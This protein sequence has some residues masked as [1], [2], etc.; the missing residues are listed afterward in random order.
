MVLKTFNL[1]EETYEKF[2]EFCRENGISMSKQINI[3]IEAQVTENPKV[4]AA[5]LRK[6]DAIRKGKFIKVSSIGDFKK[7]YA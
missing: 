1:D 2:S 6:L 4:R 5:Y 7:R 3:F